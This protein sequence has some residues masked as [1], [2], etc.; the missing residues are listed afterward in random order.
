MK[1]RITALMAASAV[2][3]AGFTAAAQIKEKSIHTS[4]SNVYLA[5]KTEDYI[6]SNTV[7]ILLQK[8]GEMKYVN[9]FPLNSDG[10]YEFKFKFPHDGDISDYEFTLNAGGEDITNSYITATAQEDMVSYEL[11]VTDNGL[12]F[13]NGE[14]F[15]SVVGIK[16][17]Y[18]DNDKFN[19]IIAVYNADGA[20]IGVEIKEINAGFDVN[21]TFDYTSG[22]GDAASAKVFLMDSVESLKPLTPH[23]AV[24]EQRYAADSFINADGSLRTDTTGKYNIVFIGGSL[25]AGDSTYEIDGSIPDDKKWANYV[26][27]NYFCNNFPNAKFSLHNMAIGGTTSEFASKRLYDHV[28]EKNPDVVFI[29]FS[30]NDTSLASEGDSSK[31][32]AADMENLVRRL[33]RLEKQPVIIITIT[34]SPFIDQTL[35]NK[36]IAKNEEIAKK[37]GIGIADINSWFAAESNNFENL[38]PLREY[39]DV[40]AQNVHPYSTGYVQFGK[41]VTDALNANPTD[42]F[43]HSDGLQEALYPNTANS[44]YRL[45]FMND[46]R[47]KLSGNWMYVEPNGTYVDENDPSRSVPQ[48]TSE[49]FGK[50]GI[51]QSYSGGDKLKITTASSELSFVYMNPPTLYT[52]N[53]VTY[54][55]DGVK[56]G[57]TTYAANPYRLNCGM[58][59]IELPA[60][61]NEHTI[62]LVT[63]EPSEA[64]ISGVAYTRHIFN[65]VYIAEKQ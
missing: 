57:T 31:N 17:K 7:T 10:S 13:K 52:N 56:K 8:D 14:E 3:F 41:I 37:Y 22:F 38:E 43:V 2:L 51:Y 18:A 46:D 47:V 5:G 26:T 63:N 53:G 20:L 65:L 25:T 30:T 23:R 16:N 34:P 28:I 29:E 58:F 1:Q 11:D 45:I 61:G 12:K 39:Y 64:V 54:Y 50:G 42:Y 24:S 62:E 36:I 19:L 6:T 32:A 21:S 33:L 15:E 44:D 40:D 9:D 60:D 55:V 27:K 49:L 48:G 59:V 35:K 4:T